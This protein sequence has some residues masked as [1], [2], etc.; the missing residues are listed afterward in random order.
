MPNR[1]ISDK[2]CKSEDYRKMTLFQRDLFVRLIVLA[3]D[4]GRYD[5][6]PSIIRG[7]GYP[8]ESVT[9]KQIGDALNILSTLGIVD[10][11]S[12]DERP[13][14]Q[15]TKWNC[16][17]QQRAKKSRYPDPVVDKPV[18]NVTCYQ[19][20]S[21]DCKC[22]R[23]RIRNEED[24][25]NLCTTCPVGMRAYELDRM[26]RTYVGLE[27]DWQ[28]IL[29]LARIMQDIE[30][31]LVRKAVIIT[32]GKRDPI[33]YLTA[34]ANDWVVRGVRTLNDFEKGQY[35]SANR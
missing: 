27:A 2:I 33:A 3:D 34:T 9:E 35:E 30:L 18:D 16:Y 14:L 22:P 20:I 29:G 4:F 7:A 23:I 19:L 28:K 24:N 21:N 8:L 26:L 12:V 11:Y 17:Q 25:N 1:F 32:I 15:L 5:G 13:Y 31:R 10:L 6:R